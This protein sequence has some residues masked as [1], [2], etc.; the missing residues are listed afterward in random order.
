MRRGY[1]LRRQRGRGLRREAA[2]E[3]LFPLGGVERFLRAVPV[4]VSLYS[5]VC[6]LALL[7]L[8]LGPAVGG[9]ESLLLALLW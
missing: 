7:F 8:L 2:G 6:F 9:P 1:V 5:F 3:R 4:I